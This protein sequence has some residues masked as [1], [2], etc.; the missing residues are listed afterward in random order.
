METAYNE[1]DFYPLH[2]KPNEINNP[3]TILSDFLADDSLTGHLERLKEWRDYVLKEDFY[4]DIKGSPAGLL[5]FYKLNIRLVEAVHLLKEITAND[6]HLELADF[7][8]SYNL[9]QYREQL[10]GWLEHGLSS[11]GAREFIETIDLIAVYENLEKLYATIWDIFI[12]SKEL[13]GSQLKSTPLQRYPDTQLQS[14]PLS[15]YQLN[16]VIPSIYE[17]LLAKVTSTIKHK[18]PTVQAVIYLGAPPDLAD[19]I[20]LLVFTSNNEQRHAQSLAS[21]IEESCRNFAKIVA[22]VHYASVLLKGIENN[23]PFYNHALSCPVI[24]LSGDLLLPPYKPLKN[25]LSNDAKSFK[26][27]RWY[28][29]GKDFLSG[30]D[31]YLKN[32]AYGAALF[33]LHQCTECLLT[34]IIRAVSSYSINNHNISR[35]LMLTVMFTDEL[36]KVFDLS[37]EFIANRFEQLK[38][39]YINVSYKDTFEPDPKVVDTLYQDIK[40]LVIKVEQVYEKHL[41]INYL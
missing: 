32:N 5:Y 40:E 28:N 26:W 36:I 27:Q 15:L 22:L 34:A 1:W 41:L 24:Y 11:H 18:L 33:S 20:Y 21:M 6:Y 19:K 4:K 38:H 23:N 8:V 17:E 29:Q 14:N 2:L 31:Y 37:D 35:L 3:L 16:D 9:P 13:T 7:F 12:R 25:S 30:A 39:A 10:F